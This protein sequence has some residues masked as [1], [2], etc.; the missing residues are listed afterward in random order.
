M[1]TEQIT[2]VL[3]VK[4]CY[5]QQKKQHPLQKGGEIPDLFRNS[6]ATSAGNILQLRRQGRLT[7]FPAM[8]CM[9]P[10]SEVE[11]VWREA[12]CDN[13]LGAKSVVSGQKGV[14]IVSVPY[15]V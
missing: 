2:P 1:P 10:L 11:R 5:V 3:D 14:L 9:A 13:A 7:Q 12:L 15:A 4:N 8:Q 6:F